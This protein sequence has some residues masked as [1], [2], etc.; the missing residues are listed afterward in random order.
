MGMPPEFKISDQD[1]TK[2]PLRDRRGDPYT[3]PNRNSFDLKDTSFVKRDVEYDPVTKQY[4][5]VERIGNKYY[6][7]PMTFSM[8]EFWSCRAEKTKKNISAKEPIHFII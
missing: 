8:K 3:Y 6:R 2:Y 7:T 5:I 4:Y 1:T